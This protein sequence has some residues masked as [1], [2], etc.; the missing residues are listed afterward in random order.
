MLEL[1]ELTID[2]LVDLVRLGE[3]T[4]LVATDTYLAR[5]RHLERRGPTLNSIITVSATDLAEAEAVD[6]AQQA[7]GLLS[8]PLHGWLR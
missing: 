3:L 1:Q 7:T 4:S 5:I 6:G 8:G 2:S